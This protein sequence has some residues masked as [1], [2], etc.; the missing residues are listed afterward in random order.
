MAFKHPVKAVDTARLRAES[1]RDLSARDSQITVDAAV[2]AGAE[3]EPEADQAPVWRLVP[4]RDARY[5]MRPA[6]QDG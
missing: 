5:R 4:Y 6:R 1:M 3:P 2:D